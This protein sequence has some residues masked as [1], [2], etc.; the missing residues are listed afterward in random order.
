MLWAFVGGTYLCSRI[1][2]NPRWLRPLGEAVSANL[3]ETRV[4]TC[5]ASRTGSR[6][7]GVVRVDARPTTHARSTPSRTFDPPPP[8]PPRVL[9]ESSSI[10]FE[11]TAISSRRPIILA[12]PLD[13][14]ETD[15]RSRA[16]SPRFELCDTDCTTAQQTTLYTESN[17]ECLLQRSSSS[18]LSQLSADSFSLLL[19]FL[20][21]NTCSLLVEARSGSGEIF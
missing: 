20:F 15:P 17:A 10:R 9:L 1:R 14:R 7:S 12:S 13:R 11:S 2:A 5:A 6:G 18:F 3:S 4:P 16:H 19:F 21:G 8:P